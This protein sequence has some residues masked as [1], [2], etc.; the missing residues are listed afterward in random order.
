MFKFWYLVEPNTPT[1]SATISASPVLI[2]NPVIHKDPSTPVGIPA[3]VM[4]NMSKVI[5][6]KV[7]ELN[8]I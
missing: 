5:L 4:K 1:N 6:L 2:K 3:E 7:N 8:L